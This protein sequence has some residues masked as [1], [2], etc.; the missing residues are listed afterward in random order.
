MACQQ[1]KMEAA[2][3]AVLCLA[4]HTSTGSAAGSSLCLCV[5]KSQSHN[6]SKPMH[7]LLRLDG[8][9]PC[10]SGASPKALHPLTYKQ[11]FTAWVGCYKSI[12]K[13]A[14]YPAHAALKPSS[15]PP[16][17]LD[18]RDDNVGPA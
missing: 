3:A 18:G 13:V 9:R 15:A 10:V 14:A 17:S 12:K 7:K 16:G 2:M 4:Q 11:L 5:P 6:M 8:T 1:F